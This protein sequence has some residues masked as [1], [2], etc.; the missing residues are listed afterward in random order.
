VELAILAN[1]PTL[2]GMP[3]PCP[4]G[5]GREPE[6]CCS[7]PLLDSELQY[8]HK[9]RERALS[10]METLRARPTLRRF[11]RNVAEIFW[12]HAL[13]EDDEDEALA[14][15]EDPGLQTVFFCFTLWDTAPHG[16]QPLAEL[17]LEEQGKRLS[18]G[19]RAFLRAGLAS[20]WGIY[21]VLDTRPGEGVLVQDLWRPRRIWIRERTASKELARF[22]VVGARILKRP[23]G[24]HEFEG[25]LL[26][27]TIRHKPGLLNLVHELHGQETEDQPELS[28]A[29][30][31][32]RSLPGIIAW[33]VPQVAAQPVVPEIT[34]A[35]GDEAR[36]CRALFAV[37]D[38]G[39]LVRVLDLATDLRRKDPDEPGWSWIEPKGSSDR[40]LGHIGFLEEHLY[41]E[42]SS[43]ERME[44][45][46]T[47]LARIAEG[48]LRFLVS[49]E[50]TL[51][52]YLER[53]PRAA[54]PQDHVPT[55]REREAVLRQMDEHYHGWLDESIPLLDG[56]TPRRAVRDPRMRTRVV[57]LLKAIENLEEQKRL[58][59]EIAYDS[60]W[61]WKE[62]G[63]ERLS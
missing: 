46:R 20:Y 25:D 19:E 10:K 40:I 26:D 61:M 18:S 42:T 12:A 15:L 30:F 21:E 35:E 16:E 34:T 37:R 51:L 54:A 52:E 36:I 7:E 27:L 32:K 59:G 33:W 47:L 14:I 49:S 48:E 24:P 39:S 13:P 28:D 45:A 41:V 8:T 53:S 57:E 60:I 55:E 4:C 23:Q 3:Q 43:I 38:R 29:E 11:G 22:D 17:L 58:Q 56:W 62:L 2:T 6:R 63:V 44:R 9:D 5:S 31:F 1:G 50:E